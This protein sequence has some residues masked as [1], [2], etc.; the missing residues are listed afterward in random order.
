MH[1][2]LRGR[3]KALSP[4]STGRGIFKKIRANVCVSR[5]D[6]DAQKS[7]KKRPREDPPGPPPSAALVPVTGDR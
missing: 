5:R 2:D 1:P 3:G 4:Q 7:P 6:R